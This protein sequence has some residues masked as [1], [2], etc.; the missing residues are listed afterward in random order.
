M[1]TSR[2]EF[3]QGLVAGS[4]ALGVGWN[5]NRAV[6]AIERE[7]LG[8]ARRQAAQRRRRIIYNNDGDDIFVPGAVTPEQFLAARH[9]PL[10]GTQVD[11]IYF[12]TTQSFN[13]YTHRT[14][15][16]EMF[17]TN[18]PAP[19]VNNLP[20]FLKQQTDGL[21]M[22]CAFSRQHGFESVWTMRMNDIHDAAEPLF[23]PQWKKTDPRRVMS[24]AQEVESLKDRRRLWSLVDF[25][26][27]EVEPRILEIIQEVLQN[28]PVDGID[29]DFMRAPFYFR[30][31]YEGKPTTD[32]QTGILTQLV[33]KIRSLVMAESERQGRVFLLSCRVPST[34]A[35]CRQIGIDIRHWL[36]SGMIDVLSISGGYIAFDQ[37]ISDLI[38]LG[39][40]HHVPVYPCLSR[41]GLRHQPPV[42]SA[43]PKSVAAW[44]GAAACILEKDADGIQVF[45]LFPGGMGNVENDFAVSIFKTIGSKETL[46]L[47][48]R[49]F[50][51]CE[52][53]LYMPAMYWAKDVEEF[54]GSLPILLSVRKPTVIPLM[55]AGPLS[56]PSK[57][58]TSELRL[59]ITGLAESDSPSISFNSQPLGHPSA[60]DN[61]A[62]IV[63]QV[64]PIPGNIVG[65][66]SATE[67]GALVRR[68]RF[69]I[70]SP[71]VRHGRNEIQVTLN[72][73]R[74]HLVG[75]ELWVTQNS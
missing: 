19:T 44:N 52:A 56:A 16:A 59:D 63:A 39:H 74:A 30:T 9:M 8:N 20:E 43:I 41:S 38:T 53:G 14:S 27:P 42:G 72:S 54:A 7:A 58:V 3:L 35:F 73:E 2:R 75:A 68:L 28:Y 60:A 17:L 45:N 67:K 18:G 62:A 49:I 29:L 5:G 12:N 47:S 61:V 37:Q 11:S 22:S 24:T 31:S 4:T 57:S 71:N 26:R 36:Q 64:S 6:T 1:F 21:K 15:V 25:E 40:A 50:E 48:D 66:P 34:E 46:T 23:V 65:L 51:V 13:L 10:L 55:V 70:A 32:K 69:A 33:E